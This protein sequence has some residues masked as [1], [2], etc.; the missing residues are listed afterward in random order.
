M[1]NIFS[2]F[3]TIFI[4]NEKANKSIDETTNKAKKSSTSFAENLGNVVKSGAKVATAVAGATTAAIAGLTAMA[5]QTAATADEI[6]KG[7][8]RMGISTD[9]YQQLKYAAGQCG[10]E[11]TALEKAAKKLEGTDINMEDAMQQIMALSTAEERATKAGELFGDTVAYTL[12]PL[13]EQN[14]EDYEGLIQRTNELGIV[15][16]EDSVKA[17]VLFGDTMSDIKQSL[18]GAFNSIM[19]SLIPVIQIVLDLIIKNMP[20]IQSMIKQISPILEELLQKLLPPMIE[21]S[22]S[23]FPIIFNLINK[24]IPPITQILNSLLPVIIDLINMLLPPIV[25]IV[26]LMG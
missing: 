14:T 25:E 24:L 9:Y 10:V 22:K 2:L 7:S 18:G 21:L 17:G 26:E 1:A 13:I 6:D 20:T 8:I 3:G 19:S 15:M 11:M 16:G 23:L 5:N 4:D 12:S